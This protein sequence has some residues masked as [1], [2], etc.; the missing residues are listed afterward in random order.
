MRDKELALE[1][2]SQIYEATK[3]VIKRF[4]PINSANDFT[5]SE[6][7]TEK[8]YTLC[9]QLFDATPCPATAGR[10][11]NRKMEFQCFVMKLGPNRWVQL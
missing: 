6:A 7:G 2:L 4:A 5:D 11:P 3:A 9:M 1:I 8:L 10:K